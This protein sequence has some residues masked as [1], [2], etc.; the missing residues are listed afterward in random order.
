MLEVMQMCPALIRA[1][2]QELVQAAAV[3]TVMVACWRVF[4]RPQAG[5]NKYTHNIQFDNFSSVTETNKFVLISLFFH[6]KN[7]HT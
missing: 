7:L 1:D 3:I 5:N 6:G 2:P 4:G